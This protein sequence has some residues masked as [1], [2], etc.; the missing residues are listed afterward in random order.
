MNMNM[1][2]NMNAS[3]NGSN[4]GSN[5][6]NSSTRESGSSNINKWCGLSP[7]LFAAVALFGT[8]DIHPFADGNGRLG[9]LV[10]N[11]A[12][13]RS[14]LPFTINICATP[15][16]RAEYVT[17]LE[18]TRRNVSLESYGNTSPDLFAFLRRGTG[19]FKPL[20]DM[21]L[22]RVVRAVAQCQQVIMEKS[23]RQSEEEEARAA[24]RYRE[25]AARGTCLICFDDN[26]NIAT[27]CCGKAV[28]I[29]C[30]AEWLSCNGSC[31]NCR[32][33]LPTL[34]RKVTAAAN[35]N[36]GGGANGNNNGANGQDVLEDLQT[37]DEIA[38]VDFESLGTGD[39]DTLNFDFSSVNNSNNNIQEEADDT[40]SEQEIIAIQD[41][42]TEDTTTE[43]TTHD[44]IPVGEETED[45]TALDTSEMDETDET[46]VHF[47][48][49][50]NSTTEET[51]TTSFDGEEDDSTEQ[52]QQYQPPASRIVICACGNCRNRAALDCSNGYCGR[53]CVMF[54]NSVCNRHSC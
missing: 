22:D 14:G 32:A 43:D 40:T 35:Q 26:P 38:T 50:N 9:R 20:V 2:M 34:S 15:V 8:V 13:I 54:G 31:P 24:K 41:T 39:Y 6:S 47:S 21:I 42:T 37:T 3:M 7:I 18:M 10:C 36:A 45:T 49:T 33:S 30:I 4:N 17:A 46:T 16:Q 11:W 23:A 52:Q 1:N 29:N 5:G 44:N 12:L 27:L 28:H 53:C 48:P 25:K 19:V 51:E